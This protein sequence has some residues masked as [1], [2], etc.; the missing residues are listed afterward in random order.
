MR[1]SLTGQIR[2]R[3]PLQPESI[4][5]IRYDWHEE[6]DR[7]EFFGAVVTV[8]DRFRDAGIAVEIDEF[9]ATRRLYA[10]SGGRVGMMFWLMG[11]AAVLVEE[12][13]P[14]TIENISAAAVR[15]LQ[16]R[17]AA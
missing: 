2:R 1:S 15:M 8:L 3:N 14:L 9:D 11:G 7:S 16:K 13:A 4:S 12:G 17:G 6:A 10:A 5:R